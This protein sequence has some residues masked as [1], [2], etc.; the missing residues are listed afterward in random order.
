MK[1]S[2]MI[3]AI[4]AMQQ[5]PD[6]KKT[7]KGKLN[8]MKTE[9]VAQV[10]ATATG[11]AKAAAAQAPALQQ[12]ARQVM[13]AQQAAIRTAMGQAPK[14]GKGTS[15][16]SG[17]NAARSP[18]K[19]AT[20]NR[21]LARSSA[22]S[23]PTTISQTKRGGRGRDP[24]KAKNMDELRNSLIKLG[25]S[26]DRLKGKKRAALEQMVRYQYQKGE[27]T[28]GGGTGAV[29]KL[30]KTYRGDYARILRL[31]KAGAILPQVRS[32]RPVEG[33]SDIP[34][35]NVKARYEAFFQ[36]Y[37]P[38]LKQK[39]FGFGAGA[40]GKVPKGKVL[41]GKQLESAPR[42]S[43]NK[44]HKPSVES[45]YAAIKQQ[46]KMPYYLA[47]GYTR[48]VGGG[49]SGPGR[50]LTVPGSGATPFGKLSDEEKRKILRWLNSDAGKKMRA[51]GAKRVVQQ[52]KVI[53]ASKP[54]T[55]GRK[56]KAA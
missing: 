47:P 43:K 28:P 53:S 15:S 46:G 56:P 4:V 30:P 18:R 12:A 20:T 11:K 14:G 39:G 41:V 6:K 13:A 3:D 35:S 10:Y 45:V 29:A 17:K 37:T 49:A 31:M 24:S 50:V 7:I 40:R 44:G 36:I 34:L 42:T 55:K 26:E 22:S 38:I 9:A 8:F 25:V 21:D 2:E 32:G 19:A 48:V 52:Q 27:T 51:K 1:R 33:V 54:V 16:S 23:K 5:D